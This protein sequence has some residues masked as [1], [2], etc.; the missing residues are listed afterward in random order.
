MG[1]IGCT[2]V[3]AP[4][5]H[6]LAA[7]RRGERDGDVVC[8]R[9]ERPCADAVERESAARSASHVLDEVAQ[10]LVGLAARLTRHLME[11]VA[12]GGG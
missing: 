4:T 5:A 9:A 8:E 12:K 2:I 10:L 7:H 11:L 3:S 1:R 6:K